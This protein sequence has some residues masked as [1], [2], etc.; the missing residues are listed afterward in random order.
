MDIKNLEK[1]QRRAT[2]LIPGYKQLAYNQ[3]LR[4]LN[5]PSL[6]YRRMRGD[7]ITAYKILN[8]ISDIRVTDKLLTLDSGI[9]TRGHHQKLYKNRC[10]SEL[11]RN[12]FTFR[13][14]DNWNALP[15][16][17]VEAETI[18]K[19]EIELDKYMGDEMFDF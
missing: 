7:L 4:K 15:P 19:F 1:V 11:R 17:V 14:V 9:R 8:N 2:K 13:I 18:Q 6:K 3:R 10:M 12:S 5:L 16:Q